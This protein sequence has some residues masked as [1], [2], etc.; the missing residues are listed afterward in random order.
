MKYITIDENRSQSGS[1]SGYASKNVEG[2]LE[3][4]EL[5]P[6]DCWILK[7]DYHEFQGALQWQV[8]R[9]MEIAYKK[10]KINTKT[11]QLI[12]DGFVE[13]EFR[14]CLD[15]EVQNNLNALYTL[16]DEVSYP[17]KLWNGD[18]EVEL[19]KVDMVAF[20]LKVFKFVNICLETGKINRD[21]LNLLS[22]EDLVNY[23]DPRTEEYILSLM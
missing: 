21:G 17:K 13:F 18:D 6:G 4:D 12:S 14:W 1:Y 10:V 11:Q 7:V 2:V 23:T 20:C 9:T 8:D 15:K 16:Q 5:C 3:V 22:D 19:S